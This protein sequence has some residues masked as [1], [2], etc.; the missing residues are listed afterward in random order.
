MI[1][2]STDDLG[3]V[4]R[5]LDQCQKNKETFVEKVCEECTDGDPST[6][7]ITKAKF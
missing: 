6:N 1:E 7:S 5:Y 3:D 4:Q 2:R